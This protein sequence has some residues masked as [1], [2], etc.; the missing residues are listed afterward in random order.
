M[1][2]IY[3][4]GIDLRTRRPL[5]EQVPF[6]D[7]LRSF[8][9]R[10]PF[11]REDEE[12][13]RGATTA[14]AKTRSLYRGVTPNLNDPAQVGYGVIS[15]PAHSALLD[16]PLAPLLQ[17]RQV[18]PEHRLVYDAGRV[19]PSGISDW[20]EDHITFKDLPYYWLFVGGP[21]DLPFDLQWIMD[22]GKATGRIEF[23]T[24]AEYGAYTDR[25]VRAERDLAT[26]QDPP[27]VYF[28]A[29]LHDN[30]T[31]QSKWYMCDPLVARLRKTGL[32]VEY[33][34][35]G[36]ATA[37]AF[38]TKAGAWGPR[39][40]LVYTAS[41]GGAV[42]RDDPQ[43]PDLQGC[44]LSMDGDI[45]GEQAATAAAAFPASVMFNFACF[46]GGTPSHS[47]LNHWI[48]EYK[49]DQYIPDVAFVSSL[50]RRLLAHSA[51]PLV[52]I[53]HV[54]AAW[55][56]S[57]L[58]PNNPEEV[59]RDPS[60]DVE[61]GERMLPFQTFVDR[62]VKGS[63]VGHAMELFG[64]LYNELGNDLVRRIN[65]YLRD[66]QTDPPVEPEV[67]RMATRWIS[68]NDYQN[69]VVFGDPAVRIA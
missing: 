41:H 23:A 4:N 27:P 7:F 13:R 57:F 62:L 14:L 16:G 50:H 8:R 35:A 26:A 64:F 33:C 24:D 20:V 43:Q 2:C 9:E 34:E 18:K 29:P 52:A 49:L 3:T 66:N 37:D 55:I 42:T 11:P 15:S 1:E 60:L 36:D 28:W 46:S 58:N 30:P 25:V 68:R 48:P 39:G 17:L 40:G 65:R 56:H 44:L 32:S 10:L 12:L 19:T 45:T 47:D 59:V 67:R 6:E 51:G 22:S 31:R 5:L 21:E 38:W 53:G 69:Y 54:E 61:W 63:T